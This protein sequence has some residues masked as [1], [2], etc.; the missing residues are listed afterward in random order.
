MARRLQNRLALAHFKVT[1][2]WEDLPFDA[3]KLRID[4]KLNGETSSDSS[5]NVSGLRYRR[6]PRATPPSRNP[7]QN[8]RRS[9]LLDDLIPTHSSKIS[10]VNMASSRP[11]QGSIRQGGDLP[12]HPSQHL[13]PQSSMITT[14]GWDGVMLGFGRPN[15]QSEDDFNDFLNLP[16]DESCCLTSD[17][18]LLGNVLTESIYDRCLNV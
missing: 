16:L 8:P 17:S 9:H 10:S 5:S 11:N 3:I 13:A 2:G 1:R 15:T 18:F 7:S 6:R 14:F 12:P 4:K